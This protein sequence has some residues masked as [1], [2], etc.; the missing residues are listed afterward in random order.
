MKDKTCSLCLKKFDVG[1]TFYVKKHY[2][3]HCV[4]KDKFVLKTKKEKLNICQKCKN[5]WFALVRNHLAIKTSDILD[6]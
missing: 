2:Y 1:Y 4:F 5:T 3:K 6:G